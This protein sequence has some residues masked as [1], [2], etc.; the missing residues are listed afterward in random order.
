MFFILFE[1]ELKLQH[2]NLKTKDS[3]YNLDEEFNPYIGKS[4]HELIKLLIQTQNLEKRRQ[5]NEALDN[6]R[7]ENFEQTEK[8]IKI[9]S[10]KLDKLQ[11]Q[12][13]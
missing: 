3:V 13:K 7:E 2:L 11:K 1:I 6:Y 10:K 4:Y 5:L 8:F 9:L 12:K